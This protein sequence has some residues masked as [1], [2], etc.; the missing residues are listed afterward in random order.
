MG[1]QMSVWKDKWAVRSI[2]DSFCGSVCLGGWR[3]LNT[4]GDKNQSSL[5]DLWQLDSFKI[6]WKALLLGKSKISGTQV[7]SAQNNFY[8]TVGYSGPLHGLSLY[9]GVFQWV[10]D[11]WKKLSSKIISVLVFEPKIFKQVTRL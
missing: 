6:F 8:A 3:L 11:N 9:S 10:E 5:V 7:P 2:D 1:K 4:S